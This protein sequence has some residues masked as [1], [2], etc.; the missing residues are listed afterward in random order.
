MGEEARPSSGRVHR[1]RRGATSGATL[2]TRRTF[3][4]HGEVYNRL[5][6]IGTDRLGNLLSTDGRGT[7]RWDSGNLFQR[8]QLT[9]LPD[10]DLA[11]YAMTSW[12]D[13]EM[14]AVELEIKRGR[15]ILQSVES[16]TDGTFAFTCELNARTRYTL[17]VLFRGNHVPS[18]RIRCNFTVPNIPREHSERVE[19]E[20]RSTHEIEGG[21][22]GW[23][24]VDE[25][26]FTA[27]LRGGNRPTLWFAG[28][29]VLVV[30]TFALDVDFVS[31]QVGEGYCRFIHRGQWWSVR[32]EHLC[33]ATCAA[34]TLRYYGLFAD[35]DE[36]RTVG[37]V[38]MMAAQYCLDHR[39]ELDLETP[40]GRPISLDTSE[41]DPEGRTLVKL[42]NDAW[43]HNS[44]RAICR[45]LRSALDGASRGGSSCVG[46]GSDDLFSVDRPK[47]TNIFGLGM[48]VILS[49]S[50]SGRWEHARLCRGIVVTHEGEVVR[51]YVNDPNHPDRTEIATDGSASDLGWVLLGCLRRQGAI[52]GTMPGGA[53]PP[54]TR[55]SSGL[56]A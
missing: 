26:T 5:R 20:V 33:L 44:D 38:A 34:M 14:A 21:R 4:V 22:G 52:L 3:V 23:S 40:E 10:D 49:D 43:P 11:D 31:Q 56:Y 47:L 42:S 35:E 54:A 9:R 37:R 25:E 27:T 53:Y 48:P 17:E 30:D 28:P 36:S 50:L 1:R 19:V 24:Q 8:E 2:S 46:S 32:L 55:R 16:E 13:R 7:I 6:Y 29:G 51:A 18:E 45:G 15:R 12:E 39:D 41:S